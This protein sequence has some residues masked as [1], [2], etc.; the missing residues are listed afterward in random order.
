MKGRHISGDHSLRL[1]SEASRGE[2]SHYVSW[3]FLQQ[4]LV[5]V[6][7]SWSLRLVAR[8]QGI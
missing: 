4:N 1:V 3:P 8:I 2:K 6:S 5:A 7:K